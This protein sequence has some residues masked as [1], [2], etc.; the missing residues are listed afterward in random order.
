MKNK[1]KIYLKPCSFVGKDQGVLLEKRNMA[2]RLCGTEN[3]FTK[4][5]VLT[6]EENS[7]IKFVPIKEFEKDFLINKQVKSSYSK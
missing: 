5:Q 6:R 2:K 3:F 1:F 4:I 7:K